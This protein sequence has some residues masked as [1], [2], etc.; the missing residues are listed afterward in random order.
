[1]ALRRGFR[2]RGDAC[3]CAASS[4]ISFFAWVMW[5]AAAAYARPS[6]ADLRSLWAWASVAYCGFFL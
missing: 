1:M 2:F 3:S 5:E 4:S 6:L